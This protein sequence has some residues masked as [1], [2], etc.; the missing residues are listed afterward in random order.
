[1][2]QDCTAPSTSRLRRMLQWIDQWTLVAFN[3]VFPHHGRR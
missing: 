1:M 2:T 3:P